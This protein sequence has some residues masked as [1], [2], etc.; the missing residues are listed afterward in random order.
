MA[1][2]TSRPSWFKMFLNIRPLIDS[3]PDDVAGRAIKASLK[4]FDT[5]NDDTSK[6]DPLTIAVFSSIKPYIDEA[7][8]D[9]NKRVENGK[10]G[11]RP[12]KARSDQECQSDSMV[13]E[14]DSRE[15]A[16]RN[17]LGGELGKGVVMLSDEQ[18]DD[19]LSKLSIPEYE[20]Y[21]KIVADSELKGHS[22]KKKTHYQA[23]LDMAEK[24]RRIVRNA[25]PVPTTSNH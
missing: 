11:G 6:Y 5:G 20:H 15:E 21:V 13:T 25:S 9:F 2:R 7:F 24:D 14:F 1:K 22:Y 4:Y 3:V 17:Y 12:Q 19:L 18:I 16:E 23:I 8:S 10:T